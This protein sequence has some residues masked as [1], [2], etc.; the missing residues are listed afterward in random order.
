M[1]NKTEQKTEVKT[2]Q[3]TKTKPAYKKKYKKEYRKKYYTEEDKSAFAKEI[4]EAIM[5]CTDRS[6]DK[7]ISFAKLLTHDATSAD[8]IEIEDIN[9]AHMINHIKEY[10]KIKKVAKYRA[11]EHL[12]AIVEFESKIIKEYREM[13]KNYISLNVCD[14]QQRAVY[15]KNNPSNNQQ[16]TKKQQPKKKTPP[17]KANVKKEVVDTVQE[18]EIP[19]TVEEN[20]VATPEKEL[21]PAEKRKQTIAAKKAEAE[22]AEKSPSTESK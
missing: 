14:Q 2:E 20:A 3:K 10:G 12:P 16:K 5:N 7:I 15:L 8:Y 22:A 11:F 17:T 4:A 13:I 6:I 21:T 9:S 19:N 1:E 18:K